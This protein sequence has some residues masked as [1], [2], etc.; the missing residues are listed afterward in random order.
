[1][2]NTG[3]NTKNHQSMLSISDLLHKTFQL[4]ETHFLEFL[5]AIGAPAIIAYIALWIGSGVF[6][7]DFNNVQTFS[8]LAGLFSFEQ[9]TLGIALLSLLIVGFANILGLIAAPL[10]AIEHETITI[11]KIVPRTLKYF[12]TYL[13]YLILFGIALLLAI[14]LAHLVLFIIDVIVA[15]FSVSLLDAINIHLETWLTNGALFLTSFFLSFAVFFIIDKQMGAWQSIKHSVQMV[16]DH[17]WAVLIRLG[18]GAICIAV[19]SFILQYIPI[20]GTFITFIVGILILV[21]YQYFIY[22]DLTE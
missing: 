14:I 8:D 11:K 12:G 21:P 15:L 10:V 18:L 9:R 3:T 22:K 1:M 5:F 20:V 6:I 7:S 13:V 2:K 19:I 16:A 17:F 4:L